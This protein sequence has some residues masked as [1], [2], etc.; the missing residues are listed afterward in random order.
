LV[1]IQGTLG[2]MNKFFLMLRRIYSARNVGWQAGG[3]VATVLLVSLGVDWWYFIHLRNSIIFPVFSLAGLLGFFI[4]LLLV[5]GMLCVGWIAKN[6]K[7]VA[8]GLAAAWAGGLGLFISSFYKFWT[9]RAHPPYVGNGTLDIASQADISHVFHFGF[10]REG[11]FWGWPSSH[12]T[13]AFAMSV[14]IAVMYRD[15][16]WVGVI[17]VVYAAYI[18]LGA[19]MSFHWLSDV[20]MGIIVGTI[21]GH[22]VGSVTRESR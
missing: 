11:V 9:G 8:T 12:T 15:K 14:A 7:L 20:V 18:A 22:A 3:V 4:P 1:L 21:V 5:L 2:V 13:V 19:S 6:A 17:A 16:K 10:G